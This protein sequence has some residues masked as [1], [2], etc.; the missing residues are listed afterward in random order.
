MRGPA[1]FRRTLYGV[2]AFVVF[3]GTVGG[4]ARASSLD[5]ELERSFRFFRYASD[6]AVQRI[7]FDLLKADGKTTTPDAIEHFLNGGAFWKQPL[8]APAARPA[9]WPAAWRSPAVVT[10]FDIL[11]LERKAEGR[12][13]SLNAAEVDRQGWAS[14][15]SESLD[16]SRAGVC[17]HAGRRLHDN[18]R[19][20]G[21]YVAPG[22][23]KVRV[24]DGAA[25]TGACEWSVDG[26][27]FSAPELKK[28]ARRAAALTR[29]V[30][31]CQETMVFVSSDGGRNPVGKA[32]VTR[33]NGGVAESVDILVQDRL[34]VGMGDSMTSGEGNPETPARFGRQMNEPLYL[35]KSEPP[36][37]KSW[38]HWTDRWCH[39]SAYSWQIRTALQMALE[40]RKTAITLLPY[41][42]SGAEIAEGLLYTYN[43]VE[44]TNDAAPVGHTAQLGVAFQ[45]LC[46][47]YDPPTAFRPLPSREL[48]VN[49]PAAHGDPDRVRRD[50]LAYVARCRSD[51]SGAFK[52]DVN[53]MLLAVGVN[54]VGFSKWVAGAIT[55]EGGLARSVIG[56]FIP[57]LGAAGACDASCKL[58][59]ARLERL[60]K[61]YDVLREV[62]QQRFLPAANLDPKNVLVAVYP[63]AVE[64]AAGKT[65]GRGNRGMTA[66]TFPGSGDE[67]RQCSGD[68]T[69]LSAWLASGPVFAV[70]RSRDLDTINGF[71]SDHLNRLAREFAG[72]AGF[73]VVDA[74]LPRFSK[75]GF[76][77][78]S[79]A[80]SIQPPGA[81]DCLDY[82]DFAKVRP[83]ACAPGDA[84][85][86]QTQAESLHVPRNYSAGDGATAG[87]WRPYLAAAFHPYRHRSRLFRTPNDVYMAINKRT[88][89]APEDSPLGALDLS[90]RFT[91]GA[92]H[93]TAEG[94]S[95]M[96]GAMADAARERLKGR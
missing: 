75:R 37:R 5:W 38:A 77:A 57:G 68:V 22:F 28:R 39:R 16:P 74:Y 9:H 54:D 63:N 71:V 4:A 13:P 93:P 79:D 61:R 20:Q 56:G 15:L 86:V 24:Y 62:M 90:D 14:L 95:I 69:V 1:A 51:G 58:T 82:V 25:T 2:A 53:L 23:W 45:E 19:E 8:P 60:E 7:A 66:A 6:N 10:P 41:G 3:A 18:C 72:K 27:S 73:S 48:D 59:K 30:A 33:T 34:I 84:A 76:C 46:K 70:R 87:E 96:A 94:H 42:C 91:S 36:G 40:D 81:P 92:F 78:T 12:A 89:T 29:M 11:T 65:C 85:C 17:W 80:E 32:R 88:P 55:K 49:L 64:D 83:K 52:R 26:G 31:P 47:P 67:F 21:D 50:A 35:P 43:G 44:H